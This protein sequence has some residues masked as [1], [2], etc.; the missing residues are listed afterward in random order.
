MVSRCYRWSVLFCVRV[1]RRAAASLAERLGGLKGCSR[2]PRCVQGRLPCGVR[3]PTV[4]E[5]TERA[6]SGGTRTH[7]R[8]QAVR[9]IKVPKRRGY[10]YLKAQRSSRGRRLPLARTRKVSTRLVH[11]KGPN[12]LLAEWA[13]RRPRARRERTGRLATHAAAARHCREARQPLHRREN[14]TSVPRR[15]PSP[16]FSP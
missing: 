4:L 9:P 8:L 16:P 13:A 2:A 1:A 7:W 14:N 10:C 6:K 12:A 3:R 15:S 5:T 11:R